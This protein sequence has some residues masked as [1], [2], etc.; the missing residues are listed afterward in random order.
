MST[1]DNPYA[2]PL[3]PVSDLHD[4]SAPAKVFSASGRLNRIRYIALSTAVSGLV[5]VGSAMLSMLLHKISPVLGALGDI[6]FI[7]VYIYFIILQFTLAMQRC[8]DFNASGWLALLV[9]VPFAVFLFWLI[10][11]T[12]GENRFGHPNPPNSTLGYLGAFVFPLIAVI[13]ILAAIAIPAYNDYVKRADARSKQPI[14]L[15]QPR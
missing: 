7:V 11:G 13:G 1:V 15:Q 12:A 9:I 14:P 3:A 4:H 2:A 10:P 6:A 8:H 5:L